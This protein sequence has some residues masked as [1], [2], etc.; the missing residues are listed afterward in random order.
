MNI[1]ILGG[2]NVKLLEIFIEQIMDLKFEIL[3]LKSQMDDKADK[4]YR[5]Y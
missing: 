5:D 3:M 2:A 4:Q 1:T